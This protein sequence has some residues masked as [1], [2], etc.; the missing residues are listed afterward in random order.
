MT[1]CATTRTT[2]GTPVRPRG[3]VMRMLVAGV[4]AVVGIGG[5]PREDGGHQDRGAERGT[6]GHGWS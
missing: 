4:C 1:T 3:E 2:P 5:C 6:E